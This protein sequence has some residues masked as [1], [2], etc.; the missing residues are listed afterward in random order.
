M[1]SGC[2]HGSRVRQPSLKL[3][4]ERGGHLPS[5]SILEPDGKEKGK[6]KVSGRSSVALV[7]PMKKREDLASPPQLPR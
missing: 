7:I 4:S 3:R 2:V 6:K 5:D 1:E